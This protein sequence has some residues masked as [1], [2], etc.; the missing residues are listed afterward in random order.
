M[1]FGVET[2]AERVECVTLTTRNPHPSEDNINALMGINP[3]ATDSQLVLMVTRNRVEAGESI[4]LSVGPSAC[5]RNCIISL[6]DKIDQRG[7]FDYF[8]LDTTPLK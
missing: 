1:R 8:K 3:S 2:L 5:Y 6:Q 4:T 7:N